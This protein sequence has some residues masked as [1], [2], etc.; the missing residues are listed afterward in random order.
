MYIIMWHPIGF[1]NRYINIHRYT[2]C[3]DQIVRFFE[4]KKVCTLND[5]KIF[6][7]M[8]YMSLLWFIKKMPLAAITASRQLLNLEQVFFP[9]AGVNR[10]NCSKKKINSIIIFLSEFLMPV[11]T[12]TL[13]LMTENSIKLLF[14]FW[15]VQIGTS[16]VLIGHWFISINQKTCSSALFI[17]LPPLKINFSL[18]MFFR[19]LKSILEC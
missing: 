1:L 19:W 18:T 5:F 8:N 4:I 16:N 7:F 3:L 17:I 2:G 14:I 9:C 6:S 10:L 15:T 11:S 12:V 13:R